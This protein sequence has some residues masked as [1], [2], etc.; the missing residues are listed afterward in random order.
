MSIH[1]DCDQNGIVTL[2]LDQVDSRANILGDVLQKALDDSLTKLEAVENLRGVIITSA[3][4]DFLAGADIDKMFAMTDPQEAAATADQ[5]KAWARRLETLGKPVVAALNGT[6]LGGGYELALACHHRIALDNPRIKIGLPEVSLGL[7]PGGGGTQRLP[8]LIGIQEAL[9]LMLQ[10]TQLNPQAAMKAGMIDALATDEPAMIHAA[11]AWIEANPTSQQVWDQKGFRIPGGGNTKPAIAQMWAIMPSMV[12]KRTQGNYPAAEAIMS[13]VF[14]GLS[15]EMDTGLRI[16]S[17]YF[18]R[19]ATSQVAKNMMQAFWLQMN[20]IKKGSSRPRDFAP[21]KINKVGVLGAG[22]MGAGIA[23]VSAMAGIDVVLKD[24]DQAAAEK[25]KGYSLKLLEKRV[26]RGK[27]SPEAQDQILGRILPTAEAA[28]LAGCDLIIEAVFEK[29]DLKATVIAEA[30]PHLAKEGFFASNTSTLP[31]TGLAEYA[32]NAQRFIGLH[33]FSPVDKMQLVEIIMGKETDQET[34]AKAFDYVQQIKKVPI[35]VNDSRGFYTSRVFTTYVLEGAAMLREGIAPSRIEAAGIAA[36]MP[37]APL[38]LCDE[39]SIS[40]MHAILTQTR[41]DLESEGK[42]HPQHPAESV[43]EAMVETHQRVGRKSG[44]GFYDYPD[45]GKKQLWSQ[46]NQ[47]V[48]DQIDLKETDQQTLIDRLLIVQA[49]E[50]A[51]CYDENVVTNA[52]DAN[53]GSIL[54]WGFAPHQGGTLQY[55]QAMGIKTF[56]RKAEALAETHGERFTPPA[57]LKEMASKGERF[58]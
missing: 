3:K 53:I 45:Q 56:I 42:H 58:Q 46:L 50:T 6:A 21:N 36:G 15:V 38:A 25:G 48:D 44:A 14:E 20:A 37:V 57:F 51:R 27:L 39:V 5:F 26:Q 16:E 40:L 28:D 35:V 33:F 12:R 11:K 41:R 22:M 23:Y 43:I 32:Q 18:G 19:I 17:R 2:T 10:G 29:R 30:E 9:G 24:I 31:I 54:G 1:F 47:L 8:R 7:L 4:K 13:C 34:L 49:V 55:I 52:A